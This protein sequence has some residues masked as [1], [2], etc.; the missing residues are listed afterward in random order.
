MRRESDWRSHLIAATPILSRHVFH[1]SHQCREHGAVNDEYYASNF[2]INATI[3]LY[4][5]AHLADEE[6]KKCLAEPAPA[7]LINILEAKDA[8]VNVEYVMGC[9]NWVLALILKIQALYRWKSEAIANKSLNIWDLIRAASSLSQQLDIECARQPDSESL[10]DT[11]T[12]VY[13]CAAM[14]YLE[15]VVSGNFPRLQKI[16]DAI[17]IQ[18]LRDGKCRLLGPVECIQDCRTQDQHL[19]QHLRDR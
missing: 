1:Q 19:E 6:N 13:A 5:L 2:L 14:V 17:A 18:R 8:G 10:S 7:Q 4:V 15:V 11:M 3:S 12:H 9:K 16:R